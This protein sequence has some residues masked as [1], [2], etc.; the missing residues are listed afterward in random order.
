MVGEM[1]GRGNVLVGKCPVGEASVGE[2]SRRG[3]VR[4]GKCPSGKRP[5]GKC[6]SAICPRGTVQLGNCPT[7]ELS[8]TPNSFVEIQLALE[9][10]NVANF[11]KTRFY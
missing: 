10:Q 6:Q 9:I 11:I 5:S 2:L 8:E 4:S 3:I 7:I 1:S